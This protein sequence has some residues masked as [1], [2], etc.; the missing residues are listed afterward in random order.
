MPNQLI[1]RKSR[2]LTEQEQKEI[3]IRQ[4]NSYLDEVRAFWLQNSNIFYN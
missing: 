2:T 4:I 3:K 1:K